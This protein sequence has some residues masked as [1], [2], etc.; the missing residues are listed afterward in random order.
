MNP[1][2]VVSSVAAQLGIAKSEVLDPTSSDAAV[3]QAHAETHIIQETKSFFKTHGVDLD[4]FKRSQRG[5]TAILI[6]NIPY[7]A[8]RD[9]IKRMFDEHG[10]IRKFLMPPS[11]VIAIVEMANAAQAKS[12]FG[13]LAYKRVKSSM[14]FL[15]KAPKDIFTSTSINAGIEEP[16]VPGKVSTSDLKSGTDNDLVVKDV[17]GTATLFV[18][19]LNFDT[20]TTQLIETFSPLTGFLSARVKT[21]TDPKK[22]GQVLS[23]GFGFIEFR[24]ATEAQAA[25]RTMDGYALHGHK[26]QVRASNKGADAA[27]E[28]R[29][30]DHAKR[31]AGHRTKIIIKNLPFEVSKKDVRAL[32]G[33]YGQLRSIRV[34]QKMDRA[35]RGFAFADFTTPKEAQSA[36]DALKD[37]HLLGRRLVLDFTEAEP[38]DAEAEIEKMAAKVGSQTNAVAVQKLTG[39]GRKKFTANQKNDDEEI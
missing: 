23:M 25:L 1:D 30:A 9:E 18:R 26:L 2:A 37:T 34:P 13:S 29:K 27:E 7:D 35:A 16:T 6:K 20:T 22:P 11:G 38:T 31:E 21:K 5:D 17:P 39:Q 8:S 32:F 28:R 12:A 19:N 14:L 24:S 3:K 15:E 4:A 36:M 33:A 10:Q